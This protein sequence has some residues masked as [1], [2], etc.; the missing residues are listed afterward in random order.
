MRQDKVQNQAMQP[1]R[2][3]LALERIEQHQWKLFEDFASK[4]LASHYPDLRTTASPSGDKGRDAELFST[5]G[6]VKVVLQFSVAKDWERKIGNTAERIKATFPDT[7]ILVYVTNQS[8][9][10]GADDIKIK[11]RNEH[12]LILDVHDMSWFLDRLSGDPGVEIAS[13]ELAKRI[14]DHTYVD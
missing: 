12:A 5:S 4:F 14:V 6:S 13:E 8:I 11:L 7:Q 9:L 10:A 2:L 1:E 3:K